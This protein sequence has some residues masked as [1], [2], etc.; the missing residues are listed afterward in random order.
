MPSTYTPG[1]IELIGD[2]EQSGNWGG[3]TNTNLQILDRMIS[4][5][6][7]ITLSG[8]THTLTISDGT[9]S[10]GQYGVLVFGG[11][12]S[13]TNTVTISPNDAQR[14]YIVKNDSSESVVLTQGS[15]GNVTVADGKT[16]LVYC[17]GAGSGA[18]V[19][20]LTA[21]LAVT[22]LTLADLGVTASASE[23][24]ILDGATLST[25]ELNILDGVTA[26]ATEI[27]QLDGNTFADDITIPD[28]IIHAGDTDTSI[29]FPAADTITV[30]T[31]GSERVRVDSG[32]NVGIGTSNP[33]GLLELT[34]NT[35]S[36][37]LNLVSTANVADAGNKIAFFA[38]DRSTTDEEMAYIKP[39]LTSNSGGAGNVQLGHLTF[40]TSGSERMRITNSG[41]VGVGTS[42]PAEE[43]DVNGTIKATNVSDG[44][45]SIPTTYVTNGSAKAWVNFNGAGTIAARDS[46]NLSSLTDNG[47]GDYTVN[48]TN[49]F[50]SSSVATVAGVRFQTGSGVAVNETWPA[51]AS[52]LRFHATNVSGVVLDAE[53][54]SLSAF[55]DLA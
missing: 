48:S 32:G 18:A 22:A 25:A 44:T 43:L 2:G 7:T 12:P 23:L 24:N 26:D 54:C 10:D 30:E 3:T 11:S 9:L 50:A 34:A 14:S 27:N 33:T 55:G 37:T 4:Q 46:L 42:S 21:D 8:T 39:L 13:G 36:G 15:G 5:A 49:A 1:G 17:D 52:A 28:K 6:G 45:L 51:S 41:N 31:A 47:T 53:F 19:V 29:R 40:G 16:A 38:A 35:G 20:D